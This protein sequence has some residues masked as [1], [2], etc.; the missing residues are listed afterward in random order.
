MQV[1]F[2][3]FDANSWYIDDVTVTTGG[4]AATAVTA[5]SGW[6]QATTKTIAG[7]TLTTFVHAVLGTDPAS[8][9]FNL[10]QSAKAAG[11]VGAYSGV[12]L[13]SPIDVTGTG[14]NGSGTAHIAP[15]VT[16]TGANRLGLTVTAANAVTSMTPPAGSTERADQAGG[17]GAPTMTIETSDFPQVTAGATVAQT[18]VTAVAATSATATITL[19]PAATAGVL[20][21]HRATSPGSNT[22][23][24][25]SITITKPVAAVAGDVLVASVAAADSAPAT[26]TLYSEGFESGVGVWTPWATG[27]TVASSPDTAR[28]GTKSLKFLPGGGQSNGRVFP[29]VT[30]GVPTTLTAYV[31]GTGTVQPYVQYFDI[32]WVSLGSATIPSVT[33]SPAA[34]TPWSVTYTAPAGTGIVQVAFQNFDVNPWYLDDFVQT[35]G[36]GNQAAAVATPA[37]WTPVTTGSTAGVTLATFTH[38]AAAGDPVSWVFN[39]SQS[40]KAA[41]SIS[42]Y[43]GVDTT[44][45]IDTSVTGVNVSGTNQV[46]PSV[47]TTGVNR[48]GV[49]ITA[50][51]A[52]T[53]MTPPAGSTERADQAGGAGVPTATVETSDFPQAAVGA[54]GV[55]T[56]VTATAATSAVATLTLR[57]ATGGGTTKVTYTRDAASRIVERKVNDVMVAR[58]TF[59]SSGDTPDAE[60]DGANVVQ[61]R[62]LGLMG[63]AVLSKA[64]GSEI[65]SI[66]NL[67][68]DTIATLN[69]TGVVT[70]GPFT[71]DP[72]GKTI[73]GA[74]DNQIGLFDNGWLGKNQ[75]P[76]EQQTGLRAVIEM[77]A[78]IYDPQLG[79]FL[80]LDQVEGGTANDYAYV[81]D[82]INQFDLTGTCSAKKGNWLQRRWCNLNNVSGGS[83]RNTGRAARWVYRRTDVSGGVCLFSCVF[84]GQQG[85]NIYI[86]RGGGPIL[87]AGVG[88]G[89]ASKQYKDRN[90][91]SS[92]S[93]FGPLS[94]YGGLGGKSAWKDFELAVGKSMGGGFGTL[95][96]TDDKYCLDGKAR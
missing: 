75:R 87:S 25:S 78:R 16:T 79:R 95:G 57:P 71:Y 4:S 29:P 21:A 77:G 68:G 12:D 59:S 34:F 84:V 46:A 51:T 70:G 19:R 18:T 53:S 47:T 64:T 93:S 96:Y 76:L 54:T 40:V 65:W 61:R 73:N 44:S 17:A 1:A 85:G 35:T 89:L 26:T 49:T 90:C 91:Q 33:L 5:P 72:F 3:N 28:T 9:V 24:G 94:T 27:P 30:V 8:W 50:A 45:P 39:L 37:G 20:P 69:S 86:A 66:S 60:L 32:N 83:A 74:P 13:A 67:H 48:L 62:T 14:F 11:T 36:G 10:A 58:Y 55:K 22:T 38:T 31:K 63:G 6:S 43:T 52:A 88:F 81:E 41:G 80:Q 2:Q 15:S 92:M 56:T 82:P 42:A 7:V 23:G